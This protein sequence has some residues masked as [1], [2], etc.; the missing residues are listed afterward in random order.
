MCGELSTSLPHRKPWKFILKTENTKEKAPNLFIFVISKLRTEVEENSKQF[1][2]LNCPGLTILFLDF[3]I[4]P[5]LL[6]S[7]NRNVD[8]AQFP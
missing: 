1:I 2:V 3:R 8:L 4:L 5:L 7:S 6:Q